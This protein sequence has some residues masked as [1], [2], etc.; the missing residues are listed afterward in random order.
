MGLDLPTVRNIGIA[1]HIDAG[2]T[3]TTERILYYTGASYKMGE[4]DDGTTITDF[5][6]EEQKRGI[7][8]YSAAVTCPWKGHT[9]NLID[10]PGHVDFTAE[11]ERSL[12]VLDGMVAVFDAKEGVE[13]QSETV[14]RQGDKY[15]V[16]RLC[17]IN[18]MDK[19]GADFEASLE[20]IVERLG[21]YPAPVQI[22]IGAESSFEGVVDL[23][24]RKAIYYDE[25]ALG[26]KFEVREIP[27]PLQGPAEA[28]RALLVERICET[29][30]AL[31]ERF[32]TEQ[33]IP[34]ADLKRGLRK[35]TIA[36]V[37]RPVLCGSSLRHIGVQQ[38]LD[39]V[40]DYLP[41]PLDVPPVHAISVD[42]HEEQVLIRTN[43]DD[44]FVG[45]AF[46][47]VA[48]KPVDIYFVRI[49]S[50][51]L[52][53]NSRVLNANT[54]EK[55]NVTRV[56]RVYAKRREVIDVAEAGDIVAIIGPKTALTG[57]TLCATNRPV[58]LETIDFP[59]TVV[60]QSIEPVS[61]RDRDKLTD[62][63]TAL[64]KQDPTFRY[65][66]DEETGQ[67]LISGMGELHLEILAKRITDDMNVPVRIGKPRV[68]Y[69]ES[70]TTAAEAEGRFVREL[71]GKQHFAVVRVRIEPLSGGT[72]HEHVFR[73]AL[74]FGVLSDAFMHAVQNG[75]QDSALSGPLLGY[76]LIN[77]RATLIGAEQHPTD[78]SEIAFENAA[79]LAFNK[80]AEAGSAVLMEP[81][82]AVEIRTPDDYFGTINADL[83][84]RRAI[85][86]DTELKGKYRL[87]KAQVPLAE[88]F[89]YTTH[90]RS[91]SQGRASASMEPLHYAAAPSRA[92]SSTG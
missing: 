91:L 63:L 66:M 43:P 13:A 72:S 84:S 9:I 67:T 68:S 36:N 18:K 57:H 76:P 28:A 37:L 82:M 45:L 52:K 83:S 41:S 29:D 85:I 32:V 6:A 53:P 38:L 24:E 44:P 48:E 51:R 20:S 30:E 56:L 35:A 71:G 62:A 3:T 79:R 90:L 31:T 89:G 5:D 64:M 50:G 23:L 88:M 46:K 80:A 75:V 11:V 61:S 58:K 33:E 81:I 34:V 19:A 1:A 74:S 49:Y 22:P 87:I 54:G 21:A 2:K 40:C 59:E 73:S 8:I 47:I 12:R 26:A 69:R 60:S 25:T 42:K 65:R 4:V 27:A 17:F 16:P 77:W 39:A 15:N 70:V 78:S 92:Q 14:W 55:E 86:T 7:T 10:T